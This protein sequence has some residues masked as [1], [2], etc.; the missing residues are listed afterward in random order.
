LTSHP[1]DAIELSLAHSIGSGTE[2]A[3]RRGE[4]REKRRV[5]MQ[6]WADFCDKVPQLAKVTPIRAKGG[7][8]ASKR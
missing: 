6:D 7:K 3:Y 4:L 8:T 2:Q 5:L 1:H